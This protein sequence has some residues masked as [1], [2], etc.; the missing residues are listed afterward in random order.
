[1]KRDANPDWI[2]YKSGGVYLDVYATKGECDDD[3]PLD[4]PAV[5]IR[6]TIVPYKKT[7][8]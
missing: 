6:I 5:P 8:E 7:K 3:F 1:M 2:L 4:T